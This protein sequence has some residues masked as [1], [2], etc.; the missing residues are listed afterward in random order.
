MTLIKGLLILE[1]FLNTDNDQS[2][3]NISNLTRLNISTTH[4]IC[5]MLERHGYLN[6]NPRTKKYALGHKIL[7]LSTS[8]TRKDRLCNVAHSYMQKLCQDF[9]EVINLAILDNLE[10][11]VVHRVE[12]NRTLVP[13]HRIGTRF[14]LHCTSVGK[15]LLAGLEDKALN[16]IL[17]QIELKPLTKYTITSKEKLLQDIFL[18]KQRGYAINDREL[19]E[20]I[21]AIGAPIKSA[22]GE[23][24]AAINIDAPVHRT[25]LWKLK[26]FAPKLIETAVSISKDMGYIVNE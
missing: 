23:V 11:V 7:S 6:R 9:K 10:A 26:Q 12:T 22:N 3:S 16:Q 2:L 13:Q 18:V 15:V 1:V 14:A 4:R 25:P 8:L 21:R 20:E 19:N 24:I 5:N 17:N